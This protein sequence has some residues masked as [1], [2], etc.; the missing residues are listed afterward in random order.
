MVIGFLGLLTEDIDNSNFH[1]ENKTSDLPEVDQDSWT[2]EMLSN[3]YT[4]YPP[5]PTPFIITQPDGSTFEAHRVGERIGGHVETMEGYTVIEGEGGWW[6]YA[7]KNEDGYLIPSDHLVGKVNPKDISE[8]ELHL[9]N[10]YP[11]VPDNTKNYQ[12][13]TR[14]PPINSTWKAIAIMLEFTNEIFDTAT[15]S[16]FETLLNSTS[17]QS[18]R[19]Y[20]QEVSYG[21]FDIE[22]D[23]V[24]PFTSAY[25]ME[26]Y[27][28]DGTGRDNAN[29]PISEMAKEAVQLADPTIDFSPYD[30]DGDGNIDALFIIHAGPGQEGGGGLD[31]IWSHMSFINYLTD[32]GVRATRY[33]TEPEDGEV[34]V[35]AHEFGHI[36]GLPD[37]YDTD[38]GGSGGESAGI[39]R[40][41]VMAGGSWNGGGSS[42]AHFCAWAKIR[43]GWAEPIIVTSDLSVSRI[44]IPPVWNNS[45]IYKIWAHDPAEDT[46]E[47]FLVENRQKSGY[48]TAL[49]GDG[50]LIWH[51]N[52]TAVNNNNPD[53]LKVD[54]EEFDNYDGTQE[55]QTPG[56]ASQASDPW[57]NTITGFRN[58][59]DPNSFSY[60]G[61]DSYVWVWNISD[62]Q[63]GGNMSLGFNEIYSGPRGIFIS[64][65]QNNDSILPVYDFI[66]NDTGFPDEDVGIDSDGNNG[67]YVL[68]W[69]PTGTSDPWED[70]P[71]QTMISWQGGGNGIINSTLLTEGFWDFR[72]RIYDEEG[73]LFYTPIVYN[74]AVPTKIPPIADAGAD[75]LTDVLRDT[76]LDG[77]GS[78]DNSGFIAWFNW[79]FGDGTYLN[80]TQSIVTHNWTDPG[81]YTVILNVSDSFGNWD[82][83]IVN[84]TVEDL[85]APVTTL[86]L[87][88]P[89]YTEHPTISMN[90]TSKTVF[91]LNS[92]DNYVGVNFTWYTIDGDY[93][94]YTGQFNFSGYL[95]GPHD[96]TWGAEDMVGNNETGNFLFIVV[97][98]TPPVTDILIGS[99]KYRN[100]PSDIWNVTNTTGFFIPAWDQ[101]AGID[102]TWH[103]IDGN[104]TLTD[105]FNLEGYGDGL[106]TIFYSSADNL[107]NYEDK[108]ITIRLDTTPPN[109]D[110]VYGDP[111]YRSQ[112]QDRW[113]FTTASE[114]SLA[115]AS[116][117]TGVGLN[118]TWY[119]IDGSYSLYT[120]SFSLTPGLHTI[121]WGSMD[122]LGNNETDNSIDIYVDNEPP[123]SSMLVG[124]PSAGMSPTYVDATTPFI[125][126][127]SD[128]LGS[129]I[130]FSYYR[131][132][133]GPWTLYTG[134]FNVPASG[135]HWIYF[136]STDNLGF[137]ESTKSYEILVDNNP[138]TS[139]ISIGDPKYGSSPQFIDST[140]PIT[141]TASDGS[142][143]GVQY[144]MYK[145]D[146]GGWN[147]YS[148][149]FTV[150]TPGPHTI[151]YNATD[152]VEHHETTNS[153][154]VTVDNNAPS[155]FLTVGEPKK[156]SFP[157]RIGISTPINLTADD[158]SGCGVASLWY[159]IDATGWVQYTGNFTVS[160][161]GDHVIYYFARDKLDHDG[162]NEQFDIFVDTAP[163]TTTPNV[164]S[165]QSGSSP[166]YVKSATQ[167]NLTADDGPGCG[168]DKIWY[169]IDSGNWDI[170]TGNFVVAGEGP[171][172]IYFNA[173]D[174]LGQDETPQTLDIYVDDTH[175]DTDYVLGNPNY[176]SSPIYIN[177]TT[178][179]S[180]AATD[181]L[182]SGV[183]FTKY[184]V[185]GSGWITYTA[186]LKF[187]NAGSYTFDFYSSDHLGNE[188]SFDT[189]NLIVDKQAPSSQIDIGEPEFPTFPPFIN[190]STPITLTS[191][192]G[193]G[194]GVNYTLYRI[195][196][197]SWN[198]YN[199]PFMIPSEGPH[200]I[201]YN[202]TDNLGQQ[203]DLNQYSV[204]VD[205]SPPETSIIIGDPQYG[206]SPTTVHTQTPITLSYN[207]G[208]GSGVRSIWYKVGSGAWTKYTGA[209]NLP[210]EGLH[211]VY[212]NST[213]NLNQM[214][215]VKSEDINCDIT[216]PDTDIT[217]GEPK[218]REDLFDV[219][220]ITL[221]TLFDLSSIDTDVDKYWFT[222]NGETYLGTQFD[223]GD[224]GLDEGF[225]TITWGAFDLLGNN[226]TGNM[227]T[228]FLDTSTPATV[229]TV[230]NPKYR[231]SASDNWI[232]TTETDFYVSSTY[233]ISGIK[234]TWYTID[235]N[236]D[237]G[238]LFDLSSYPDGIYIITWGTEDNLGHNETGNS[239]EI[240]LDSDYVFLDLVMGEPRYR[241]S[242]TDLYN[243]TTET[244]FTLTR[245]KNYLDVDQT[246]Y[247]IDDTE[248][249]GTSFNLLGFPEG[250]RTIKF[251][252]IDNF[253]TKETWETILVYLDSSPPTTIID[254]GEP[255][256]QEPE[257]G[258]LK[259]TPETT[260]TLTSSDTYS[261]VAYIW[262]AVDGTQYPG[263]SFDL[264]GFSDGEYLIK[265][266]ANDNL[267]FE[268]TA[269]ELY[270]KIDTEP[271][272]IVID[273]GQPNSTRDDVIT[274]TSYTPITLRSL[275]TNPT[276]IKYRLDG[277]IEDI[278]YT[279]PFTVPQ[280]TTRIIYFGIDVL[281]NTGEESEFEIV[282]NDNDH[283]D[284]GKLDLVDEDDD[285]DGLFDHEEDSNG[286]GILDEDESDP[287][288]A[289]TDSDGHID[290]LD[291][292]PQDASRYR[293]PTDWEK[294]PV[295]GGYEQDL[296]ITFIIIG[297]IILILL[298]YLFRRYRMFRAKSSWSKE[299]EGNGIPQ[300]GNGT[301]QNNK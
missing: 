201:Y 200:T 29:G 221:D 181:G 89:K 72:A 24:G 176:G 256:Y 289:D 270:I 104:F 59:T 45:V 83:D 178:T 251:G 87:G 247:S 187:P 185:D 131:I 95:E 242:T 294:I 188:E 161:P 204:R 129:G 148:G 7:I 292:Y 126:T 82:I 279:G 229:L 213:D 183:S 248:F 25:T 284:D 120:G 254:I 264:D 115:N 199:G 159:N 20:Y 291:K 150:S 179:I 263:D 143:S 106:H 298:L 166:I 224:Y 49:P 206:S 44:E 13:S 173:T 123:V 38:D 141:L 170:Y 135:T 234:F 32:D 105:N 295:L 8:L 62:I 52:E 50:I 122:L 149:P 70:T 218:F 198:V 211:T 26:W 226:E 265:W 17:G 40:W 96:F 280:G 80:G 172:T 220:N 67:S 210:S 245:F 237:E 71:G 253:G 228:V 233:R 215:P 139:S 145:I 156:G 244:P 153:Y 43:L 278:E 250:L 255:K 293:D 193:T 61:S 77:S 273:I 119:T 39:G 55:L 260:F 239:M 194:S 272:V 169:K 165:P 127:G 158:G 133:S 140:T 116:D 75:N 174:I 192:D 27:G 208:T 130:D 85:G 222:I 154:E 283:D 285:N 113:N 219:W 186:E 18:M 114:M 189:L 57:K 146:T 288:N 182:G 108:N 76:I 240:I 217:V 258:F 301:P 128:G 241:A 42:P 28:E 68:E 53:R 112:P 138:P 78:T 21:Q 180:L 10:E 60:N 225:Y 88:N 1:S 107:G 282:I 12:R 125:I 51:I 103:S 168:V 290:S 94:L 230:G 30:V 259:V 144:I 209:F 93:F 177:S 261:G 252:T 111:K 124:T 268:E 41:G 257:D 271:P 98:D 297:I 216:A 167:F 281:G 6:T 91:A 121:T 214:E 65:P 147:L 58:D 90:V 73:H 5:D 300:N 97:D 236:Y 196:L 171:H 23:V 31:A 109:T 22:V 296:C 15:K 269:N 137:E 9:S 86:I 117:G 34:G 16:D 207:D 286:N 223:L 162:L 84:I 74:V 142:E 175:P 110:A 151:Y 118:F 235:G 46:T 266:G 14:A 195:D 160:N 262:Y 276:T 163:P 48:D 164:G 249:T 36:L 66:I 92:V 232:V 69:R 35:F 81:V 136:N 202:A 157:T 64:D 56:G 274:I 54:L 155:I 231:E 277:G 205:N 243:V 212:F 101:Y 11:D 190:S 102:Y 19:T 99:P 152:W 287:L 100:S 2:Y 191:S 132:D 227:L 4:T 197:G 63:A 184:R 203:E 275:D 238:N 299:A 3:G 33:S 47:Y 134:P 246:W 79:S 37:L 267:D